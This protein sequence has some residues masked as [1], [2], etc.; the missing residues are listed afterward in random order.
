MG[1]IEKQIQDLRYLEWTKTRHSSGTAGSFL[2]AFETRGGRKLYYKLSDYDSVQGIVGH[3]CVNEIIADRLLSILNIEHL[4]YRLI[5]ARIQIR[6]TEHETYLCVSE[7]FKEKGE[8]KIALDAFYDMEAEP[9][10]K[11]LDFCM[12]MGWADY[13]WD[14]LT[15]DH[16]IQNRDRHGANMEVLRSKKDKTIRLAPLFDHGLSFV[17]A[18]HD[19]ESLSKQQAFEELRIQC[20]VG[21]NS[22]R[23]NLSLIPVSKMKELPMLDENIKHQLFADLDNIVTDRW[24]NTVWEQLKWRAEIYEDIRNNR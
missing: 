21:S 23:D 5:H 19:D 1:Q 13:I 20:F 22:A 9:G 3:E 15:I 12:R 24:I 11:P 16:L 4:S 17:F 10:E 6:G 2:K 18:C 8:S 7:D 14:M